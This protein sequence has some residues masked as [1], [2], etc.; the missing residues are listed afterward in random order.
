MES[1]MSK[2]SSS[3]AVTPRNMT[4]GP[5]MSVWNED[6]AVSAFASSL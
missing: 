6:S 4:D 1:M 3:L 5:L 2:M